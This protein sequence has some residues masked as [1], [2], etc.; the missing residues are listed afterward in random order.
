MSLCARLLCARLLNFGYSWARQSITN[1]MPSDYRRLALDIAE[2]VTSDTRV[3]MC[4]RK[5]ER[6]LA[7]IDENMKRIQTN[8]N[9]HLQYIDVLK[10]ELSINR[11]AAMTHIEIVRNVVLEVKG[12]KRPPT[13]PKREQTKDWES[14]TIVR[15]RY[16]IILALLCLVL[17]TFGYLYT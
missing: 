7:K 4:L 1:K 5:V 9:D 8:V 2:G 12:P 6:D 17:S 15:S 16:S 3:V 11:K 14:D 10:K 13:S